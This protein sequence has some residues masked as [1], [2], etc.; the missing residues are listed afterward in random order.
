L[1]VP[2]NIAA[3]SANGNITVTHI[4]ADYGTETA[5]YPLQGEEN[6]YY[7]QFDVTHF[8]EFVV[9]AGG[10]LFTGHS[11]TLNG[12]IN[13]NFYLNLAESQVTTGEGTVVNFTWDRGNAS[14][15]IKTTDY[16]E[17][18]GYK[19]TVAL[20][21]AE[22]TY[23]IT[24]T[25]EINGVEQAETNTYSVRQYADELLAITSD[26]KL[27]NLVNTMLDYG[28]KAQDAFGRTDVAYANAGI[29]YTMQSVTGDMINSAIYDA[30]GRYADDMSVKSGNIGAYAYTPSLIFLS[31]CTLRQYFIGF[32]GQGLNGNFDGTKSAGE[33]T[34]YYVDKTNIAAAELD[35]LQEFNV[36]GVTF[37]YSAL[38]YVRAIVCNYDESDPGYKLAAATYWYNQAANAYFANN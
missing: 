22:M 25:V 19:A 33:Y 8:S 24:A 3:A 10:S 31:G 37:S 36:G 26:I 28:A 30:N 17:G 6:N 15:K 21:A 20:P 2:N 35:T 29:N 1:A 7:V 34:A 32:I 38:D 13:L 11:V 9:E 16:F 27:I 12:Y 18:R 4:S 23:G 14:Y 5:I